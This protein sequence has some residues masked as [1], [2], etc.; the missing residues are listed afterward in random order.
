MEKRGICLENIAFLGEK[1]SAKQ[2]W[3]FRDDTFNTFGH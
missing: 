1:K 2:G 3:G